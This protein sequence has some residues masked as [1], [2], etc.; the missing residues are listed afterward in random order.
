MNAHRSA[1]RLFNLTV[2]HA[3]ARPVGR[4]EVESKDSF[5]RGLLFK[6]VLVQNAACTK[7]LKS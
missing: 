5:W 3:S 1:S 7:A 2:L 4:A 6:S